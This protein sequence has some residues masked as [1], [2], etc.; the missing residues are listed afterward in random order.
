MANDKNQGNKII[1]SNK[2]AY[3]DIKYFGGKNNEKKSFVSITDND[4]SGNVWF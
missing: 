1:S 3:F 2:K 4:C